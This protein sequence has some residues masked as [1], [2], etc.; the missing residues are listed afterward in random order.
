MPSTSSSDQKSST[1]T[2]TYDTARSET[3]MLATTTPEAESPLSS[4]PKT[5]L[6][7]SIGALTKRLKAGGTPA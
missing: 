7:L 4:P 6:K 3:E 2:K 1:T 5:H